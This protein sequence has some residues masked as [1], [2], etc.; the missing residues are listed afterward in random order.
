MLD[1]LI[2]IKRSD[3]RR[4]HGKA[5]AP[6]NFERVEQ[7]CEVDIDRKAALCARA[8]K[9]AKLPFVIQRWIAKW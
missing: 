3:P 1:K 6:V 9:R 7:L 4:S 5:K 2:K 8:R